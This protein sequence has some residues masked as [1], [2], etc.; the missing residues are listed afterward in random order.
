M[1]PRLFH[2][3][4]FKVEKVQCD[5]I[6]ITLAIVEMCVVVLEEWNSSSLLKRSCEDLLYGL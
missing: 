5:H 2:L 1:N 6:V 4:T 3:S